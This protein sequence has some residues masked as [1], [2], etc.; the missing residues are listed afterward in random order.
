MIRADTC[1]YVHNGQKTPCSMWVIFLHVFYLFARI[2][3][4]V[5]T[6]TY[7]HVHI[8]AIT[9]KTMTQFEQGFFCPS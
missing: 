4:H 1:Q 3:V 2:Y 6:C 5:R 7:M 9:C 8:L